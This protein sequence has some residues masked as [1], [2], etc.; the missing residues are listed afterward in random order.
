[1][2]MEGRGQEPGCLMGPGCEPA[3]AAARLSHEPNTHAL[4]LAVAFLPAAGQAA[5]AVAAAGQ[6]RRALQRRDERHP[7][8]GAAWHGAVR[9]GGSRVLQLQIDVVSCCMVMG[10]EVEAAKMP[11]WNRG[12]CRPAP[13]L[14]RKLAAHHGLKLPALRPCRS[15]PT[16]PPPLPRCCSQVAS[17]IEGA[18]NAGNA[19]LY[20][21]VQVG[22][23]PPGPA[24]CG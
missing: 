9:F 3:Q 21:C 22:G 2:P 15:N 1:M 8:A 11:L 14:R 20:E 17:N 13:G 12:A 19:I 16:P 6:G 18:R 7:G 4:L 5:A 23:H 24:V 10:R